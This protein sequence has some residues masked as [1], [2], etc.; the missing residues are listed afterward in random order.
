[1][2]HPAQL[3]LIFR[4]KR[5]NDRVDSAKLSKLLYLDEVPVVHVPGVDVRAWRGLI[6]YRRNLV[7]RRAAVKTQVRAL[8]R[9]LGVAVTAVRG[10][11]TAKGIAWLKAQAQRHGARGGGR[12]EHA[13]GRL[14]GSIDWLATAKL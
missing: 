1:M 9:G 14:P 8:L 3:R 4:S 7:C 6:N 11:W 5:K 2:A 12:R 10:L 13:E